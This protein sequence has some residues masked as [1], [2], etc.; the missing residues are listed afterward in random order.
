[1]QSVEAYM[2]HSG[3]QYKSTTGIYNNNNAQR[4]MKAGVSARLARDSALSDSTNAS[5]KQAYHTGA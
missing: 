3:I 2:M 1:M 5:K 4:N